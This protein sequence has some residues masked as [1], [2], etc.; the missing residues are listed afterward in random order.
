MLPK[1]FLRQQAQDRY[2]QRARLLAE[3]VHCLSGPA[4]AEPALLSPTGDGRIVRGGPRLCQPMRLSG[5]T[6]L[7]DLRLGQPLLDSLIQ[8]HGIGVGPGGLEQSA[9]LSLQFGDLV[10]VAGVA[11][12]VVH[13]VRIAS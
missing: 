7:P 3:N 10:G 1:H 9:Q 6:P 13:L 8:G 12:Q 2:A 4:A 5:C 11:E